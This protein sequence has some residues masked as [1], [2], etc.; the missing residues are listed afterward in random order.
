MNDKDAT[1][2]C[3]K[4]KIVKD[5]SRLSCIQLDRFTGHMLP[6]LLGTAVCKTKASRTVCQWTEA[7]K[8]VLPSWIGLPYQ[9]L[10]THG[11]AL[12]R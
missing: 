12:L 1:L 2:A 9:P 4:T 5:Q 7:D 3:I 6:G 8:A 11:G 10:A